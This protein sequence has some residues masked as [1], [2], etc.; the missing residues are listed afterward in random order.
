MPPELK[1]CGFMASNKHDNNRVINNAAWIIGVKVVQ[2][3]VALAITM[4]SA[5]YLGPNNYGLINYA[6]SL[7]AFVLPLAQ[8]GLRNVLVDQIISHPE[9]EGKTVGTALVMSMFSSLFCIV[10]CVT[11]VSVV[12]AGEEDTL[13]VCALY[14]ISLFFQMSEM[15]EYWYQAKLLSKYTSLVSLAAYVI[16][17]VY[18]VFL[19][20]TQKS[21][22][23][24]AVTNALDFLLISIALLVL[25]RKL[26]NDKLSFSFD[27]AK[28][29]FSTSK[30][31]I[32][33]GMMVTIFGQTD[34]IMLKLMIDDAATG[35]YST[36]A[37]CA[38]MSGFVF[39]AVIDSMRPLILE[40]K[41]T[42]E[43]KF[44]RNMSRLYSVII[45][46]GLIQ[47]VLFTLLAKPIVL[48]LY[49][50]AY[51]AAIPVLR[52]VTWYSA[53]SYMGSVR[54]IWILAEGKQ[55]HLW[56]IN[57]SGAVLNVIG[58]YVLIP[59]LGA[60][61][62]AI[63]FV[64]TQFFTNFVLCLI[65]QPIRPTAKLILKAMNP[66]LILEMIPHKEKHNDEQ[67]IHK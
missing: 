43:G 31:Y 67:L 1:W 62:A 23:W 49:G 17:A 24:F 55:K 32:V 65:M 13:I 63:A 45:Y 11:F 9:R 27:L 38:A 3:I 41:R 60:S 22:Y 50:E 15:I 51:S 58:N 33:S 16:V 42:D 14:S 5:R 34:K 20:I 29:L 12:N 56:K 66:K 2:S 18:R 37:T 21:I 54:N 35:Y 25:Y 61:G 7:I 26:G 30:Y 19:L 36:A 53:F 52:I 8:L 4:L 59:R 47:S 44:R 10:G 64:A 40:S 48:L 6:S 39:S 28:E 46:M 57:L